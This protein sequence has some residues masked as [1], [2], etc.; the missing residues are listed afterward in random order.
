MTGCNW[1]AV[2]GAVIDVVGTVDCHLALSLVWLLYTIR[3]Q[4]VCG[5]L[6]REVASRIST[7]TSS[8]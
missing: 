4:R 8:S 3:R 5:L 6:F 7:S 2:K 1:F